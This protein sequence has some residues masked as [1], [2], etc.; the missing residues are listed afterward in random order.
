M[1]KC[2]KLDWQASIR[3]EHVTVS[4]SFE[5]FEQSQ[6]F[7]AMVIKFIQDER[8]PEDILPDVAWYCPPQLVS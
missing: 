5:N 8:E 1:S 6:R 4:I 7:V 2:R 3:S